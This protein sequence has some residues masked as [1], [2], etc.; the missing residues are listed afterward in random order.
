MALVVPTAARLAT[1]A[2]ARLAVDGAANGREAAFRVNR[3]RSHRS[4]HAVIATARQATGERVH[5]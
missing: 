5:I 3:T 1:W 4:G 2:L